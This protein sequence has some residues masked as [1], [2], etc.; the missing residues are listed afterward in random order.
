MASP[1]LKLFG[2]SPFKHL[3]DHMA[4]VF[5]CITHLE[6]FICA[7][8]A[9]D[10]DEADLHRQKIVDLEHEADTLKRRLRLD[11]PKG[12]FLPVA[13]S[14]LLELVSHQDYIANKTKDIVGLISGRKMRFPAA[15]TDD[16]LALVKSSIDTTKLANKATRELK[17]LFE[18]GFSGQE[19]D[20]I[21]KML[22]HLDHA[23]HCSDKAQ[24]KVY[25]SIFQIEETLPPIEVM[26][27][28]KILEWTGVLA[29]LA[30]KV[31]DR[32]LICI[33]R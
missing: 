31:G 24:I 13:R 27:L 14:D 15:I 10:W 12:L 23:E 19:K 32:L 26:F 9:Q 28:Y 1:F 25:H 8:I 5:D 30:E 4:I 29:D 6:P 17:E 16:Y 3:Q 7:V 18:A 11:L 22:K 20:I 21:K 33:S 2:R